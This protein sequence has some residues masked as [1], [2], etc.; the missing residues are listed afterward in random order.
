M[1]EFEKTHRLMTDIAEF[2]CQ[3]ELDY[4]LNLSMHTSDRFMGVMGLNDIKSNNHRIPYCSLKKSNTG[5]WYKCIAC[6]R[7]VTA[8]FIKNPEPCF[9]RCCFG[10][11]E[12]VLPVFSREKPIGFISVTGYSFDPDATRRQAMRHIENLP[13]GY[14]AALAALRRERPNEELLLKLLRPAA[15]LFGMI[16]LQTDRGTMSDFSYRAMLNFISRHF[17]E[18]LTVDIIA[19]AVHCSVSYVNH[20]FKRRSGMSVSAYINLL[21]VSRAKELLRETTRPVGEI[22]YSVGFN[23]ANYFSGVFKREVGMTPVEYR[24][25]YH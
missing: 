23:D 12:F 19:R 14:E 25:N 10:V 4:D 15:D 13:D 1:D 9:G 7:M 20:T 6:Q 18:P 5:R 24:Q 8:H 3:L 16:Y 22:A 11:D 2:L 21:R 17:D